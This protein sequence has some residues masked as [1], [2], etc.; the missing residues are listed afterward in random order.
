MWFPWE[1]FFY[2]WAW[3][4][5]SGDTL[6][7]L[8]NYAWWTLIESQELWWFAVSG[9][10]SQQ[11]QFPFQ[12][13]EANAPDSYKSLQPTWK[14]FWVKSCFSFIQPALRWET[15]SILLAVPL[16]PKARQ[17]LIKEN[18]NEEASA[19]QTSS[20]IVASTFFWSFVDAVNGTLWSYLERAGATAMV[21]LPEGL[22]QLRFL[23][24]LG[25]P[26]LAKGASPA[27][28]L[29]KPWTYCCLPRHCWV[30]GTAFSQR[31]SKSVAIVVLVYRSKLANLFSFKRAIQLSQRGQ[32]ERPHK[33]YL[34]CH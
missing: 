31:Q 12:K 23:F 21:Y 26:A 4:L 7:T 13:W 27:W 9:A 29:P 14:N 16:R 30:K 3:I 24:S 8:Q 34:C 2:F 5:L 11:N 22:V 28:L 18:T 1:V 17:L 33:E 32:R 10:V 15:A 20:G 6:G 25:S 19:G